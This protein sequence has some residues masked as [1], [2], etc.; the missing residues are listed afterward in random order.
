MKRRDFVVASCLAGVGPLVAGREGWADQADASKKEWYELRL[1]QLKAG[2]KAEA[3]GQFLQDTAVAALNRI[4]IA[5]V[6]VFRFADADNPNLTVLLPHKTLESAVTSTARLLADKQY[7]KAGAAILDAPQNDPAFERIESSLLLAFD[8]CPK[9]ELPTQ[10]DTR[11]FQLR[12]Y[13]S[14]TAKKAQRKVEMFNTGGEIDIF[15]ATGLPPVF[16]GEALMGTRIPNLTYLLGFDDIAAMEAGW[17]RFLA[18][19][20]WNALKQ[21]PIYQDTVSNITN[22]ILRPAPGSQI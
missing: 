13:E 16:F 15:R 6:G 22:L 5:P 10:K 17:K 20:E 19:P 12:I 1:Y 3:F 7:L 18:A 4:G 14:H 9:I 8:H 11:V 21:K 2:Q